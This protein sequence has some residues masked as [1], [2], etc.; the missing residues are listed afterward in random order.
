MIR[1]CRYAMVVLAW[2]AC[3]A[4]AAPAGESQGMLEVRVKDHREAIGDFSKLILA[5]DAVSISANAGYKFWRSG[6]K[7]LTPALASLD[8]TRYTGP[9]SATVFR[10][11]V[12][13]GS[14]DAIHLKVRTVEATLK[15]TRGQAQLKNS[16][17]PIK[18]AFATRSAG[19]TVIVID[20][21]VLDVSDHPPQ[22]YQ[23]AIRGYELYVD[24][25]LKDKIPPG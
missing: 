6:W 17:G 12:G 3:A 23:L 15:K 2:I 18:L 25:K 9:H 22:A 10:G 16:V 4:V 5:F 14:Y 21:V 11:P 24:G 13:A 19:E 1:L 20:L 7:D 8:L